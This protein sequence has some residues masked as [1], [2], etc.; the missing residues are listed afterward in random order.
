MK[1][2]KL[3]STLILLTISYLAQSQCSNFIID[4][5]DSFEYSTVCPYIIPGTTYQTAPQ[6]SPGFGPSYTG[7]RHIYL[8]FANGFT[9]AAFSRP[10]SVCVGGTYRLSFYHRDAWGG[11]NNTTFNVYDANNVL[12]T[13][14]IVPWNGLAWNQWV[15]PELTATTTTLRLEIVNNSANIGNNDMCV[16]DM[17]LEVCS[18]TEN[19]VLLTCN[20]PGITNLF[21]LFSVNMPNTG[22]WNGPSIL[23]NGFQGTFD[24]ASDAEGV[25]TYTTNGTPGCP[26]PSGTVTVTGG[27][28]V[29]LGS[30]VFVCLPQ[31]TVFDAGTGYDMYLWSTGAITQTI[32]VS[33][34]GVYSVDASR[35][36]GNLIENG[37]F[38][39]GT[40]AAANNFTTQY[41][42][43]TGGGWGLLSNGGQYGIGTN[44]S[45]MH[46]NFSTCGDHTTGNG[47]M[48]IANGASTANTIVWEQTVQID[49]N[50]DYFFSFWAMNVVNDPNV[51]NLQLFINGNPIG[52]INTTSVA[53]AWSQISD[54]W[55][56]GAATSAILSIRNFATTGSGNDFAIDDIQFSPFCTFYDEVEII[57]ASTTHTT[58]I[59]DLTC[60]ANGTGEIEIVN[61]EGVNYSFDNQGTW[62]TS[63]TLVGVAAGNYTVWSENQYG[64]K[65]SS[66]VSVTEPPVLGI[67]VSNDTLV[68]ENGTA[69]IS[70]TATVNPSDYHW[71]FTTDLSA[72]QSVSPINDSI[73][74]VYAQDANGCVS[75]TEQIQITVR[76]PLDGSISAPI[77]MCP[78]YPETIGVQGL[79]GGLAPY[80]ITWS[81]GEVGNGNA[82]N[83]QVN[84][85][86]TQAY[87]VTIA[88]VCETTPF[89]MDVTVTVAPLP[90]PSMISLDPSICEPASFSL[91]NTTDPA[92]T[93]T[94]TWILSD[95]Q[96][97]LNQNDVTTEAMPAGS[98]DVQMIVTSPDG[99]IDSTTNHDYLTVYPMPTANFNWSPNPVQ[100]FNTEVSFSNLSFLGVDYEWTFEDGSQLYSYIESPK[101][102]FPE[103][104]TGNYEVTLIAT[105]EFGCSDTIT[106]IVEVLPEVI[107]YVPNTF[108]PDGDEFNQNWGVSIEGLDIYDFSLN[109]FNRWGELVWESHDPYDTWDGTYNGKLVP[110]GMY[111]WT[112]RAGDMVNDSRYEWNGYVNVLR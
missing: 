91:M 42:P 50:Q 81:S 76:A 8:N 29:D 58:N 54:T 6:P 59:I 24:A 84:P 20:S 107:I 14:S 82:M 88:D 15:S 5:S 37:D 13:S 94:V 7:A 96:F 44:P 102:Q 67:T 48:F 97:F 95:G 40:T 71:D 27:E 106:K 39:G 61:A 23:A 79:N 52:P 78:G 32:N 63:P 57:L 108:T 100:M 77:T 93:Q 75:A 41:V 86:V 38:Q 103:G 105:T 80:T 43:G 45:A 51:S 65:F 3:L 25:Y 104:V 26:T 46:N 33:N 19:K 56:S 111:S 36:G 83:I 18:L 55:N 21:D 112:I 4:N 87:Q 69:S 73:V 30:D 99:C 22:T 35:M 90:V 72:N 60:N 64:C 10:Y 31:N 34:P 1:I 12:L 101:I 11:Q 62:T 74:E 53:C 47:N 85:A 9:G 2:M 28:P 110:N 89:L 66:A 16:D 70:A 92:M 68:C 17:I 98:Y 49:P 109:V